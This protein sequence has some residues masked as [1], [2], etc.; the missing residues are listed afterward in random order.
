M[1]STRVLAAPLYGL[2][3]LANEA[4][5]PDME[6]EALRGFIRGR[7]MTLL[8]RPLRSALI[9]TWSCLDKPHVA[10]H[11]LGCRACVLRDCDI[12]AIRARAPREERPL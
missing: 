5:A 9:W 4:K 1:R 3:E 12:P 7:V 6:S 10:R 11:I 8:R 2:E